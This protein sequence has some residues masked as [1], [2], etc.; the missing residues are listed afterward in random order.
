M[1]FMDHLV[2]TSVGKQPT[3]EVSD[4][5]PSRVHGGNQY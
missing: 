3:A 2:N 5:V 4:L 1:I